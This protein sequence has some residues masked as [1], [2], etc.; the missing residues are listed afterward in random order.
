[1][2]HSYN[3]DGTLLCD[4]ALQGKIVR[5]LIKTLIIIKAGDLFSYFDMFVFEA[6]VSCYALIYQITC[7]YRVLCNVI[8]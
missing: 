2:M 7:L 6:K 5:T 8:F 3:V 1:M 4:I